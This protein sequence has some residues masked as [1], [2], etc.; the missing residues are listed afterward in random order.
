MVQS[1][2]MNSYRIIDLIHP[3]YISALIKLRTIQEK[4]RYYGWMHDK[5]VVDIL[6]AYISKGWVDVKL[7]DVKDF[8]FTEKN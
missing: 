3:K 7:E 2:L 4:N 5:D 6:E 8:K 1:I